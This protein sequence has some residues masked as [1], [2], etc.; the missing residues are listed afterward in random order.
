MMHHSE[1]ILRILFIIA[2]IYPSNYN[3]SRILVVAP[4]YGT[5][6]KIIM[7]T[8][9][10]ELTK[11]GHDVTIV[12]RNIMIDPPPNYH[13]I[14]VDRNEELENM[15]ASE[16]PRITQFKQLWLMWTTS[17]SA[18]AFILNSP[19]VKNFTANDTSHFDLVI[20]EL[21]YQDVTYA[22]AQ[23]YNAPLVLVDTTTFFSHMG[24]FM[25]NPIP[26]TYATHEAYRADDIDTLAGKC[27][28]AILTVFDR[29]GRRYF[30]HPEVDKI[31]GEYYVNWKGSL[32]KIDDLVKRIS[33][34][35]VNTHFSFDPVIPLVPGVV[36][37]GGAHIQ[38]HKKLPTDVQKFLDDAKYGAIYFSF[39]SHWRTKYMGKRIEVFLEAFR[40]LKQRII[41][42]SDES[43]PKL[44]NLL[45]GQ[46]FPQSDILAHPNVKLFISHGGM[47]ST[48]EA[49]HYGVPILGIPL[50]WDQYSN[51]FK[52]KK[53]GAALR[54][55]YTALTLEDLS[56]ALNEMLSNPEYSDNMKKI[57]S[58]FRD[59][60]NTPLETAMYW[61]EYVI[62][63]NGSE[64]LKSPMANMSFVDY[65]TFELLLV[66]F[67]IVLF[68]L[69][70]VMLVMTF[71]TCQSTHV[72]IENVKNVKKIN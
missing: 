63:H 53:L 52:L 9:S 33:L 62:R 30:Y 34:I 46:W 28:N 2:A 47:L 58:R 71:R 32:P 3:A 64:F 4:F 57:S 5:A 61:L 19:A 60:L 56:M 27:M 8:I 21:F 10:L 40:G 37:I 14:A 55:D 38:P 42:K 23:K 66:L 6:H 65:Y 59:R 69:L 49:V 70:L 45:T 67:V 11:K 26:L 72:V 15:D 35:L 44:D 48:Q 13:Q 25:G 22:L 12:T 51:V 43:L 18:M 29:L 1:H 39:G 54:L 24:E 17:V 16:I 31:I 41:W 36:Q 20:C 68:A 7:E 50:F